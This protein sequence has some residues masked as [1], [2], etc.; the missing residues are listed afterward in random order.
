MA[1]YIAA[2]PGNPVTDIQATQGVFF[3]MKPEKIYRND[4]AS[5]R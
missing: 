1:A 3:V 2:M 4:D 5:G